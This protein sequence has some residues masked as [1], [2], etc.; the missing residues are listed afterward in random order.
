MPSATLDQEDLTTLVNWA[1]AYGMS[2]GLLP[3][4]RELVARIELAN[5]L[6]R[7]FLAVRWLDADAGPPPGFPSS[8][9]PAQSI[10]LDRYGSPWTYEEVMQA[11]S[12]QTANPVTVEVTTDRTKS[13]GWFALATFFGR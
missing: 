9:P 4:I 3:S 7:R 10:E 13:V 11:V 12:A 5:S 8:W 1:E 2:A 6:V